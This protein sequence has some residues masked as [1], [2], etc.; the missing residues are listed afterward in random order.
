MTISLSTDMKRRY[1]DKEKSSILR[2]MGV[3]ADTREQVWGHVKA[4]LEAAS[5]PLERGKLDQGDYTA[6]VP[7]NSFPGFCDVPGVYSLQDEVVIE[8][9][10]NLDEIA[11]NFTTGRD[12][13][14][15]EFIRAKSKGIKV[16]LV[17]E[18]AS[19]ADIMSHNYRS[20][21]SPK[22]L[23]GSLLSWQAKYNV[24]IVFCRPEETG[25]ILY[26]TLYYWLKARL[27]E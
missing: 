22:S 12:R 11:G 8:R 7:M 13:F 3:L 14:E 26:S 24:T 20:Q 10:A 4:S 19:W 16:F 2:S 15:R 27:E 25:K 6:F 23:M 1:T 5:C 17:V 18:N 21:L 9:K